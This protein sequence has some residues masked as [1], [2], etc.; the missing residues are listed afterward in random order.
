MPTWSVL[1]VAALGCLF[2]AGA[3]V[4]N[5]HPGPY[6]WAMISLT[7]AFAVSAVVFLITG[8]IMAP[9][10]DLRFSDP[11]LG[12]LTIFGNQL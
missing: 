2:V 8:L 9:W 11:A 1:L 5:S 10:T 7:L 4:W 3:A 12:I 6:E